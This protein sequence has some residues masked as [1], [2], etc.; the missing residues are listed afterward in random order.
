M[1]FMTPN[2][3]KVKKTLFLACL[4]FACT[5]VRLWAGEVSL[6]TARMAGERFLATTVLGEEKAGMQLD[7]VYAATDRG[8]L[9]YYVFNVVGGGFVVIAGDDRVKPVLAYSTEGKY[10]PVNVAE[11]FAFVL[12]TFRQEIR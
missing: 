12:E 10:D 9:D 2:P 4:L 8:E 1:I 3:C 11:G 6:Q 7:L 5:T